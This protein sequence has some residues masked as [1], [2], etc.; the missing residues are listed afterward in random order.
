MNALL[1]SHNADESA[2]LRLALQRAGFA[3]RVSTDL[4]VVI[5]EWQSQPSDLVLLSFLQQVPLEQIRELRSYTEAPFVV[6]TNPVGEDLHVE[7]LETGVDLIVFRP[8]SARLL[9]AQLRCLLRRFT[10]VSVLNLPNFTLGDLS[11]DPSTRTV[12]IKDEPSKNLT[13]LEFRLLYT[14]MVHGGQTMLTETL[15]EN[16]W[17]Y[18]GSGDR[19]LVRGLVK[20][21]RTKI[22]PEPHAPRY[23]LTISGV[24]YKLNI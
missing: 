10:G 20:R 15:V 18:S 16:V 6:V 7:L 3:A 14:L 12:Q 5:Q 1:L 9:I 21:L 19:D 13:R 4:K 22:E 8:F 24:G 17:G 11:L 23:I 2:V